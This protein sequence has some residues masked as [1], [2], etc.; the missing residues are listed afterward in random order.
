MAKTKNPPVGRSLDEFI[1]EQRAN[2]P[3]FRAE[4]DRLQ[5]ARKVKGL[6]EEDESGPSRRARGYEQPNIARLGS[7]KV[8]PRRDFLEKVARAL[9]GRLDVGVIEGKW[10]SDCVDPRSPCVTAVGEV[11]SA[12]IGCAIR[13]SQPSKLGYVCGAT[14]LHWK[15]FAGQSY[16]T[17]P[18]LGPAFQYQGEGGGAEQNCWVRVETQ[19]GVQ[20]DPSSPEWVGFSCTPQQ[21]IVVWDVRTPPSGSEQLRA[22]S[23]S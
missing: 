22:H 4:F 11:A 13:Q 9:G 3:E 18:A 21:A 2:D 5:L 14:Q 7:G 19:S 15:A 6:R 10:T 17:V 12:L 20:A 23:D 1:V 8:V 16:V